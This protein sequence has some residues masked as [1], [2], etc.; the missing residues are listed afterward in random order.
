MRIWLGSALAGSVVAA[1][2]MG[3]LDTFSIFAVTTPSSHVHVSVVVAL[4]Y[5]FALH[6]SL[7][8]LVAR[9]LLLEHADVALAGG[10]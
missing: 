10:R 4:G 5:S 1:A 8:S 2:V 6:N 7:K 9:R 3:V